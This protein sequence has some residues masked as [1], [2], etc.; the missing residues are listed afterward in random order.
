LALDPASLDAR[1]ND[2]AGA[3][4]AGQHSYGPELGSPGQANPPCHSN[5]EGDAG[6]APAPEDPE[7]E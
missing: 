6:D 4:C 1:A 5:P 2:D 7:P 3:W